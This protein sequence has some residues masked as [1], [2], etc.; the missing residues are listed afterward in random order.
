MIL[1][2]L[3]SIILTSQAQES[4]QC[5]TLGFNMGISEPLVSLEK[6]DK[7]YVVTGFNLQKEVSGRWLERPYYDLNL[8]LKSDYKNLLL[9]EKVK[10]GPF[11]SEKKAHQVACENQYNAKM[12]LLKKYK[13][14]KPIQP[15]IKFEI[16]LNP[17]AS[18]ELLQLTFNQNIGCQLKDKS[19]ELGNWL[20]DQGFA[21]TLGYNG[22]YFAY[23]V[24]KEDDYDP[25]SLLQLRGPYR[26]LEKAAQVACYLRQKYFLRKKAE[27]KETK[28]NLTWG[29]LCQ[30]NPIPFVENSPL[31]EQRPRVGLVPHE[32]EIMINFDQLKILN[33]WMPKYKSLTQQDR[34]NQIQPDVLLIIEQILAS[35]NTKLI[36][37]L[38]QYEKK[39]LKGKHPLSVPLKFKIK[40][41]QW[42]MVLDF[43]HE[44]LTT[45]AV[46][47][48]WPHI[49]LVNPKRLGDLYLTTHE[50]ALGQYCQLF[51]DHFNL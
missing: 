38:S 23:E 18:R 25:L 45:Q 39:I 2:L 32:L 46:A 22:E 49:P 17:G 48:R 31:L 11:E 6:T 24:V 13:L 29:Q 19:L 47:T 12:K 15:K 42:L 5:K 7:G 9:F 43:K 34:R 30:S 27:F 3:L 50:D 26:S 16:M 21:Y 51:K 33:T 44:E 41:V 36:S 8:K 35:K 37:D 10:L 4:L 1:S 40:T 14:A 20:Y 28:K